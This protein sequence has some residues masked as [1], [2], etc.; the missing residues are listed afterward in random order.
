LIREVPDIFVSGHTHKMAISYYNNILII[1]TAS[2]EKQNKYQ[3]RMGN[4]P[5]FCK[6]PAFNLKTRQINILDF[7]NISENISEKDLEYNSEN[8]N[9][10]EI[11]LRNELK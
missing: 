11:N 10:T 8:E 4:K 3:E 6:I 7:E 1:S 9:Y 2:W 5:D